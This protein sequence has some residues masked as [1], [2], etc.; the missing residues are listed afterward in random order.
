VCIFDA[1]LFDE[2]FA[3][4][5]SDNREGIF[6]LPARRRLPGGPFEGWPFEREAI[7]AYTEDLAVFPAAR[8]GLT[9]AWRFRRQ[10]GL[11]DE[12]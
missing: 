7:L 11:S 6:E 8:A 4:M 5:V 2:L 1:H 9:L 12:M 10:L 3:R